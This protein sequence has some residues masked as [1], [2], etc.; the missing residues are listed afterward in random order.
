MFHI[1]VGGNHT[2]HKTDQGQNGVVSMTL[3]N[4]SCYCVLFNSVLLD[5]DG[6]HAISKEIVS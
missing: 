4:F 1:V 3:L 2:V 6:V 5:L